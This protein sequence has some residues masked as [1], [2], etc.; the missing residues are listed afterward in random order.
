M[1]RAQRRSLSALGLHGGFGLD[2]MRP[3]RLFCCQCGTVLVLRNTGEALLV[4]RNPVVRHVRLGK[5]DDPLPKLDDRNKIGS[6]LD[7][8]EISPG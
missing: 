5:A 2:P 4:A 7:A 3:A 1:G 8:T 6:D